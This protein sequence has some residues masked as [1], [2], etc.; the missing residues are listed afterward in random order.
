MIDL[1]E[2][3]L[4]KIDQRIYEIDEELNK[5]RQKEKVKEELERI[6]GVLL[7]Y[8]DMEGK[9]ATTIS[10]AQDRTNHHFMRSYP[11]VCLYKGR[12]NLSRFISAYADEKS[13]NLYGKD[14]EKKLVESGY[15]KRLEE[16]LKKFEKNKVKQETVSQAKV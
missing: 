4:L 15:V 6:K 16:M 1:K 9:V 7:W 3:S 11:A 13:L 2:I 12:A 5:L 10:T 14:A 8:L